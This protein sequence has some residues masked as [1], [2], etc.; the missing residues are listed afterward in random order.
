MSVDPGVRDPGRGDGAMRR[1]RAGSAPGSDDLHVR[2]GSAAA[3]GCA[4]LVTPES[5]G[6]SH[7]GLAVV[8]LQ[9]GEVR[10]WA[11]GAA[12]TLVLSL[13]GSC[14]VTCDGETLVVTGRRD[15]FSGPSD[16]VYLPRD[17]VVELSSA[18]GGRFALPSTVCTRAVPSSWT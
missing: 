18:G 4:V 1:S 14:S 6:W 16:F 13:T 17:A 3:D 15:V 7:C 9:P 12:E 2:A 10:S 8:E 5:A 11:T